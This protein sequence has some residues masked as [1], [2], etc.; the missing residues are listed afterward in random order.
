MSFRLEP[1]KA[2]SAQRGIERRF[3]FPPAV[4]GPDELGVV[5][6]ESDPSSI[7]VGNYYAA[8]RGIP[9]EN[10]IRLRFPSGRE[11]LPKVE[12]EALRERLVALTPSRVQAYALAWTTPFRVDC[13]SVTSAVAFG[14]D[15]AYCSASVCARTRPSPYFDSSSRTPFADYGIRP[16]M[17][18]AGINTSEVKAMIDRGV[19]ADRS[20]PTGTG[21]LVATSDRARSVRA[22][23]FDET[24]ARL[25]AGVRLVRV[26][27]DSIRDKDDVMF[28][29]TGAVRVTDLD[30]LHFRPGA[31]ADHL[32][33]VGGY[34]TGTGQMSSL[35]WLEAG[36]TASF[37]TVTEPCN[38]LEKFP[39]PGVAIA[40]YAAGETA[41]EAYWKSVQQPGEGVFIGEPLAAPYAPTTRLQPGRAMV[42]IYTAAPKTLILESAAGPTGPYSRGLER[43]PLAP[44]SNQI[45]VELAD[46]A[47]YYRLVYSN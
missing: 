23:A 32:T 25:G 45:G 14:Y 39:F 1:A 40:H 17:L 15:P 46:P 35:R 3:S 33:S 41:L 20:Y 18:L 10:L 7:E 5:I 42:H 34:L 22:V 30:R 28:Y 12:F 38:H 36:A 13:M 31:L 27:A 6:N 4:L 47:R 2:E 44:G 26:N 43:Y 11:N 8:K 24:I 29:F 9:E 37:G 19:A 16:A 21:Y